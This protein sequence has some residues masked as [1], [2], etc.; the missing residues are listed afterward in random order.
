M[1][2]SP[3]LTVNF[4]TDYLLYSLYSEY[5]ISASLA[6][7]CPLRLKYTINSKGFMCDIIM[8]KGEPVK[9]DGNKFV[10]NHH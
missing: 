8:S 4:F 5:Q 1:S 2:S 7:I 3:F 9:I 6:K 10:V